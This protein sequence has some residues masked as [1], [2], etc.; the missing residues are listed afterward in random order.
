LPASVEAIRASDDLLGRWTILKINALDDFALELA[1]AV[2]EQQPGLRTARNLYARVALTPK[3]E[4]WYSQSLDNS[5]ARYDFTAIMA[6]PFMEKAADPAAFFRELVAAVNDRG[7]MRKVVFE[8]QTVD[9]RDD[10]PVP[11]RELADTVASLYAMGVQH[12]A[13]YPDRPF[14]NHPDP[15]VMRAVLST[16]PDAPELRR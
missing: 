1:A 16:K 4:V 3:A 15:A 9:W 14:G 6:M 5:T 10:R 7:A 8:L 12:V 13:Y 11:T 2:R